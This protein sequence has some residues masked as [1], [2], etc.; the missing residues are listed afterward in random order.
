M[1]KVAAPDDKL[2]LGKA[3]KQCL[4]LVYFSRYKFEEIESPDVGSV[5]EKDCGWQ[6][7]LEVFEFAH[8]LPKRSQ[9]S[10]QNL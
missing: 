2:P 9:R 6:E 3:S 1:D 5:I 10:Q 7:G 8:E 4:L